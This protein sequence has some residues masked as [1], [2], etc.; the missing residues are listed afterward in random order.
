MKKNRDLTHGR[1]L[2]HKLAALRTVAR[3]IGLIGERPCLVPS[4][5]ERRALAEQY[6]W[7]LALGVEGL[8]SANPVSRAASGLLLECFVPRWKE[9]LPPEFVGGVL[10]RGDREVLDWRKA[11]LAR[12]GQRCTSCGSAQKLHAH[13]VVRW[14]DAPS[15]RVVLD[16]G[17]TLCRGCH[18]DVHAKGT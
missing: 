11:V 16:N 17:V 9:I 6:P 4:I 5:E 1:W 3:L 10:D 12:D 15:L 14:V 8:T 2:V 18:E 7:M 13:H